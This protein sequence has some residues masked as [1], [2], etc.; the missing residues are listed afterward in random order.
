MSINIS[1]TPKAFS[2]T[3]EDQIYTFFRNTDPNLRYFN[4]YFKE[5]T[6][7]TLLTRF[8]CPVTV[9]SGQL[10]DFAYVNVKDIVNAYIFQS[11][12]NKDALSFTPDGCLQ[13][14]LDV[15]PVVG[16]AEVLT[17]K[18]TT[19]KC[20]VIPGNGLNQE[21]L[22]NLYLVGGANTAGS[23]QFLS[24][25]NAFY[26]KIMIGQ[27]EPLS[28]I[29][30][31][32]THFATVGIGFHITPGPSIGSINF[33]RGNLNPNEYLFQFNFSKAIAQNAGLS[34]VDSAKYVSLK[35]IQD[36]Y[37]QV[38]VDKYYQLITKED[39]FSEFSCDQQARIVN[40]IWRNRLGGYEKYYFVDN[41]T[42]S[43]TDK[44]TY[45]ASDL[46]FS[47]ADSNTYIF[48]RSQGGKDVYFKDYIN[49]HYRKTDTHTLLSPTLSDQEAI[50]LSGL[51]ESPEVYV[52]TATSIRPIRITD[53]QYQYK[54]KA[55]DKLFR[56]ELSYETVQEI[57]N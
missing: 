56:L 25:S 19:T 35:V 18:L 55:A 38:S 5:A 42:V 13:Y 26:K 15:Y 27:S 46:K 29:V 40:L 51:I 1:Q 9:D 31:D 20:M 33:P 36:N 50:W 41:R 47:P 48:K 32:P 44:P 53:T 49:M 54:R 39:L 30:A 6:T 22:F 2:Q 12:T 11:Y 28:F 16:G 57:I 17:E 4:I 7:N 8:K 10:Y 34:W 43:N 23:R 52:E 3:N 14:F 37:A 21:Q 45:E 24:E